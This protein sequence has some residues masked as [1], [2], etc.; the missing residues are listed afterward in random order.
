MPRSFLERLGAGEVM[1]SDGATGT[2]YQS[3]GMEIGVAPEE[4]VLDWPENVLALHSAFV[5]AGSDIIL[6][7]TFGGTRVRMRDNPYA[8]R[9]PEVN[10]RAAAL[11]R[12]AAA[13]R[14]G[15]SWPDRWV[16]PACCASRSES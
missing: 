5:D 12:E 4:W 7:C 9:A 14:P 3:M 10:R 8:D 16:R 6:T 11:A 13:Q 1:V 2:N 15:F